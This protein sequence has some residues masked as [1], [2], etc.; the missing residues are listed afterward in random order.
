MRDI[1]KVILG[2]AR[3]LADRKMPVDDLAYLVSNVEWD[4]I[5]EDMKGVARFE[6]SY[7]PMGRVH[8]L[9]IGYLEVKRRYA[10]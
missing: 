6:S 10:P 2:V 7:E 5:L 8:S 3:E 4:E 9:K 1:T